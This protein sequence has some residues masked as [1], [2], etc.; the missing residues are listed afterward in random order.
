[1]IQFSCSLIFKC[2]RSSGFSWR[3]DSPFPFYVL[4]DL[5]KSCG[6]GGVKGRALNLENVGILSETSIDSDFYIKKEILSS[7]LYL[8]LMF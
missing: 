3:W 6:V 7:T 1:M 4:K 2:G 5:K 8:L